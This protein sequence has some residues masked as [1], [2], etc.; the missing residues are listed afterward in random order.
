MDDAFTKPA[1]KVKCSAPCAIAN[2][3]GIDMS[4]LADYL[5]PST[6]QTVI[7]IRLVV[8]GR[9]NKG[10]EVIM[11]V[12]PKDGAKMSLLWIRPYISFR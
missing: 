2:S 3:Q 6:D 1:F 10:K 5:Q 11:D 7:G 12:R 8:P 9:L 4:Y